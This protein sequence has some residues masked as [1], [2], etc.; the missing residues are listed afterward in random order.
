MQSTGQADRQDSNERARHTWEAKAVGSQRAVSPAGSRGYFDEIRAYRYGYETPFVP[1]FFDFA[2]LAG[3]RVLEIGVGNGIDAMEMLRSGAVY[4]G[5]DITCNHLDLTRRHVKLVGPGNIPGRVEAIVEGDLLETPLPGGYDVV[6]SFGV[7]H[8]IAHEADY[9]RRI[10]EL[11]RP[12]GELRVAFYSRFS[13]FNI[14]LLATWLVRNRRRNSLA[15]WQAHVAEGSPLGTP[16]VIK[17][18]SRA[19][20]QAL[21]EANGFEVVRYGK[22]GFVQ[23]YLPLVGRF[24]AP[25]GAVLNGCARLLG[26]YHCFVCRRT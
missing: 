4:T 22:K 7:L 14:W 1:G 12:G 10:R 6:Y 9:L 25:N 8:H 13:F 17:I 23:R 15:D 21:L 18:R 16:V 20:I 26:W 11:L 5:I 2:G 3:K 24:L 19:A